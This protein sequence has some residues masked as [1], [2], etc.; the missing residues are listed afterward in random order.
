MPARALRLKG[1]GSGG[2]LA[3]DQILYD[4]FLDGLEKVLVN[5][6]G[7]FF[8]KGAELKIKYIVYEGADKG[9]EIIAEIDCDKITGKDTDAIRELSQSLGF[10]DK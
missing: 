2:N 6:N 5:W 1:I 10:P 9:T 3:R 4:G 7:Y 8:E